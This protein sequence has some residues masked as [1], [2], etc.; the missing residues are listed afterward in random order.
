[1]LRPSPFQALPDDKAK[2]KGQF[3]LARS[4]LESAQSLF[5]PK[6]GGA[7]GFT[8]LADRYC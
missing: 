7:N 6:L 2:S 4:E 3:T 8:D 5:Q 1:M